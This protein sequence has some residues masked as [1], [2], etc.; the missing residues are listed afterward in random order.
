MTLCQATFDEFGMP[1]AHNRWCIPKRDQHFQLDMVKQ[2]SSE[3][4][5]FDHEDTTFHLT[6]YAHEV[7]HGTI[8]M[9][10][11]SHT[12]SGTPIHAQWRT[13]SAS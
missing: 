11:F 1:S 12:Y 7:G 6:E 5:V 9:A 2:I 8:L 10:V 13:R 3:I 4:C